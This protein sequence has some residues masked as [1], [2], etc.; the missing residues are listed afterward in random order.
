MVTEGKIRSISKD[1]FTNG[2]LVEYVTTAP[3][4]SW[5]NGITPETELDIDIKQHREKRSLNANNYFYALIGKIATKLGLTNT[6][7][8]NIEISEN[9]QPEEGLT[10]ELRRDIQWQKLKEI[11]LRPTGETSQNEFGVE[12]YTAQVMRGSHTYNTEEM[13]QLIRGTIEDAKALGIQTATPD[14]IAR[15]EETWRPQLR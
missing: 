2:W 13:S 4:S 5:A 7:V 11:H 12:F 14:E 15:M 9:G 1:I 3:P 10:V 8:H 6:E